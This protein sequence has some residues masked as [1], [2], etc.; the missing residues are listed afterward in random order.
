MGFQTEA[1]TVGLDDI[2]TQ[3]KST[4][5][6]VDDFVNQNKQYRSEMP[7]NTG[8]PWAG[9]GL[10]GTNIPDTTGIQA[11]KVPA[12]QDAIKDYVTSLR[13]HL[14][15]VVADATTKNAFAGA[16][17]E[18][19]TEFVKKLKESCQNIISNLLMFSDK[20]EEIKNAYAE[21]AETMAGDIGD[22]SSKMASSFTEY[23]T[24][25]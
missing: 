10:W 4:T 9:F 18:A 15:N 14:D 13:N 7:V 2:R 20:L 3:I 17:A 19:T 5:E 23:N 12:M 8:S 22:Q 25:Y 24:K 11:S 16:Y 6:D 21:R 1:K